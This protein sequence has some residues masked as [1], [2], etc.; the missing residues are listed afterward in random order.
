[1]E[2]IREDLHED[3][4][5]ISTVASV[6]TGYIETVIAKHVP[7]VRSMPNTPCLV[8]MGMTA[9]CAGTYAKPQHLEVGRK[10]FDGLR[11]TINWVKGNMDA[12]TGLSASG[13]AYIYIII[14]SLAEGG[15][16]MGLP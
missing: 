8:R 1:L 5:L 15:V 7:V 4:L 3:K 2:E 11:G 10:I 13:P 16:K 14:E 12:V 6:P 9:L